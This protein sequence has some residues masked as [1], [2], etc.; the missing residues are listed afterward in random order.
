MFN[1]RM[2]TNLSAN[3]YTEYK[4]AQSN[5]GIELRGVLGAIKNAAAR[6]GVDFA[7]L[8]NKA[9]QESGLNPSAKATTSSATGLYQF[10]KQTW[11]QMVKD[12]GSDYGLSKEA[13]AID[14]QDGKAV[15]KDPALREKILNLRHDPVLSAAMAAE[16]TK[17]NKDYL[18]SS[19]GGTIGSTEL[20]LAH[21]L[22]AGGASKF[23]NTMHQSPNATAAD[24]LPE[25]A[26]ANPSVFYN[27]SGDALSLKDVY[28][29][30]A[31]KFSDK[32]VTRFASLTS[33]DA[34]ASI[35]A[36]ATGLGTGASVIPARF[37]SNASSYNAQASDADPL[38]S[39]KRSITTSDTLFN[40]M[41]M[42]QNSMNESLNNF[43]GTG[44]DK[45]ISHIA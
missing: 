16:F 23:L 30:F 6:T 10:V 24:L 42:A 32:G 37:A 38:D 33:E 8:V 18:A 39:W 15:V 12:H 20:Y 4:K 28:N 36:T 31:A 19:V 9:D 5:Q 3:A 29:R 25:A 26:D 13:A 35:A 34:T 44:K 43:A 22:G 45:P 27:K 40:V 41:M 1:P 21:F 7:Y 17:D 2:T 11:L 14:V